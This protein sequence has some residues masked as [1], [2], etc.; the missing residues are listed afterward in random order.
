MP[1]SRSNKVKFDGELQKN[2]YH[3]DGSRYKVNLTRSKLTLGKPEAEIKNRHEAFIDSDAE[4][5]QNLIKF[6]IAIAH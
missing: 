1:C 5:P 3:E 4:M 2:T 6:G